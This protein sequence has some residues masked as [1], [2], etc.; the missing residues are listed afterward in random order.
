M[1]HR[2]ITAALGLILLAGVAIAGCGEQAPPGPGPA[3]TQTP[4]PACG[5]GDTFEYAVTCGTDATTYT[6][7]V[8]GSETIDNVDCYRI[9]VDIQPPAQRVTIAGNSTVVSGEMWV[10]KDTLILKRKKPVALVT[11]PDYGEIT[12]V[13][14]LNY[15]YT[16][17]AGW[18]WSVG[19]EWAYM[20][21]VNSSTGQH[22]VL[23][24][25]VEVTAVED[26]S[27]PAGDFTCYR[28]EHSNQQGDVTLVEWWAD[29]LSLSV[30][31]VDYGNY[32]EPETRELQSY[33]GPQ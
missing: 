8:N 32:A 4:A 2:T 15:S 3:S 27:V 29:Y 31:A 7:T 18:P 13:T 12:A 16:I 11:H 30:K 21:D 23:N 9:D 6:M 26:I 22:Y 5:I 14:T 10:C 28:L 33:T 24:N 20:L 19:R 17:S 1:R 25:S